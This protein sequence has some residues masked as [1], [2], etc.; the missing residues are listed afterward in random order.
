MKTPALFIGHGSPMNAIENNSFTKCFSAVAQSFEKP[1]A[2]VCVSAHWQ[3]KDTFVT[4]MTS[5]KTIHDFGGF[6][7]ELYRQQYSAKGDEAL[8]KKIKSLVKIT[9]IKLDTSWGLDHGTWSILKHMYPKA[10]VP[11]VQLSL[12][13]TKDAAFIFALAKELKSLRDENILL[14]GSGN[15]IHNLRMVAWDKLD[16]EFGFDWAIAL[17]EEIK[18]QIKAQDYEKLI[19]YQNIPNAFKG[20]PSSEHFLPLL[21]TLGLKEAGEKLEF[22]NDVFVGGS[23]SMTCLKLG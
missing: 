3:T 16:K 23:L 18:S 5:P 9:D 7:Q 12:D 2:I 21:F 4:A 20:I 11:V 10:D 1:N 14:L 8:A 6:P 13:Y 17:S 15:I 19:A 22:F